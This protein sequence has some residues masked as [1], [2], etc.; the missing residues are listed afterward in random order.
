M[1]NSDKAFYV[2]GTR[3]AVWK[4]LEEWV[5]SDKP[6]CFLI[7]AAGMGNS[8]I[9]SEFCRRYE[10]Q[11]G[12]S[13]FFKRN[14]RNIGSTRIFFTTLAYQLAHCSWKELAHQGELNNWDTTDNSKAYFAAQ[15]GHY[16]VL[17]IADIAINQIAS[18]DNIR[19]LRDLLPSRHQHIPYRH[20]YSSAT[21]TTVP[22]HI[23]MPQDT[24]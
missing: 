12:A 1:S 18:P 15:R 9:A 5:S 23:P 14:D 7:G 11:L 2:S 10:T 4:R 20:P 17:Y 21:R 24:N 16:S 6:I 22:F 13:F 19:L 8:T 3:E